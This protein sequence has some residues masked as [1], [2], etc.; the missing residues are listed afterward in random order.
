MVIEI[1]IIENT[2]NRLFFDLRGVD[3]TF[4]N[5][6]KEELWNDSDVKVSS[7]RTGHPLVSVP[8]I[9]VETSKK[10]ALDAVLSAI[11]RIESTNKKFLAAFDKI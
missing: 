1:N 2:K 9:I 10:S 8:Q 3:H 11:K 4:C 6:F 5:M 7:Y